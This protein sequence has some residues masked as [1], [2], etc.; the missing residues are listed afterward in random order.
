M[1]EEGRPPEVVDV[2][3]LMDDIRAR[4]AAA[5]AREGDEPPAGAETGDDALA[6][7]RARAVL[8]YEPTVGESGAP[9]VGGLVTGV[10]GLLARGLSQPGYGLV[11]QIN[12]HNAALVAYLAR[13]EE[14][15]ASLDA[16]LEEARTRIA[17]LEA[18]A[19]A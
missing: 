7:L 10:K 6:T 2:D 12:E 3:L 16:Q 15:V 14:R 1:T 18:D 17:R 13:L 8:R 11:A 9:V 4:V 5:R 19:D